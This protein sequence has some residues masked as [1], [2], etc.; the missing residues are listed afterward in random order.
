MK[1]NPSLLSMLFIN[2]FDKSRDTFGKGKKKP[3]IINKTKLVCFEKTK[4]T[5]M[6]WMLA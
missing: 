4:T 1:K 2:R 3:N 6:G 5:S